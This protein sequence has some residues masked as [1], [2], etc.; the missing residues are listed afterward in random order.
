MLPSL[1][2]RGILLEKTTHGFEN[3][4]VLNPAVLRN[5]EGIHLWYRA[6]SKTHGSVIGY[7]HFDIQ[8]Q[9]LGRDEIPTLY[10]QASY[11]CQGVEDPRIVL[12]DGVFYL[13]Y[14]AFDGHNARGALAISNDR[15][16]WEKQGLI[17]ADIRFADFILLAESNRPL[18]EKYHRY[19]QP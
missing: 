14:T 4:G 19:N 10:P 6:L 1:K 17:V 2:K 16:H 7:A 11:E 8:G 18:N 15:I 3:L 12:M 9:L 5:S 13:T